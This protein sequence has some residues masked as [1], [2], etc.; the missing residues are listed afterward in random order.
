MTAADAGTATKL[1]LLW[2]AY[3]GLCTV[4]EEAAGRLAAEHGLR[5][6]IV[7]VDTDPALEAQWG[8]FVP[9]L[10]LGEPQRDHELCHYHLDAD[11]LRRA[12]ARR[13]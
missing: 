10:F 9:V 1:V 5:L 4:M 8:D 13:D 11:R 6:E 12:L 2:R 3:C 7:D